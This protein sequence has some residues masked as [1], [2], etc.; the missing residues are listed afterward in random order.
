MWAGIAVGT[1]THYG[2][3]GTGIKS[4]WGQDFSTP[5][6]TG[7]GAHPDPYTIGTM[8]LSRG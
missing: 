7:P 8:S 4:W 1:A 3:D 6:Q 5:I 2:L